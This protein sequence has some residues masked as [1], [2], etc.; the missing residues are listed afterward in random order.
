M[1]N[2]HPRI[3]GGRYEVIGDGPIA[4]QWN[5]ALAE[6]FPWADHRNCRQR[7]WVDEQTQRWQP[8][9][10]PRCVD[11]HCPRCGASTNVMGHHDCAAV[12]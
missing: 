6:L 2:D 4:V 11:Y 7:M 5:D 10:P 3:I 12:T 9:D 8:Y 1:S